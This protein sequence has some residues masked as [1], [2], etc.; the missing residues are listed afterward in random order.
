MARAR[1]QA[2]RA[3]QARA[4]QALAQARGILTCQ[5]CRCRNQTCFPWI[6]SIP[7]QTCPMVQVQAQATQAWATQAWATQARATQAWAIRARAIPIPTQALAQVRGIQTCRTCR[8]RSQTCSPS[9]P[10]RTCRRVPARV[11]DRA[12]RV[13]PIRPSK[14]NRKRNTAST[15]REGRHGCRNR[16]DV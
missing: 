2:T 13:H 3:T 15:I 6:P 11:R 14:M 10:C 5:T 16:A 9:I 12:T 4:N 7:C 8:C 1:A